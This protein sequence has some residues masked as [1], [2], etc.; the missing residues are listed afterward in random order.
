MGKRGRR[1]FTTEQFI[2]QAKKVHDDKYDY[3]KVEYMNTN[4]KVCIICPE[5]GEF[6][7]RPADHLLGHGCPSCKKKNSLK[8]TEQFIEQARKI[9]GDKYDYSKVDYKGSFTKVCIICPEHGEFWQTPRN[10]LNGHGCP[11][12]SY[13]KERFTTEQFIE[14][15]K[16]VHGDDK[17]DYS[18]VHYVDSRTK[19][20]LICKKC[21]REF[22][23]Y[24]NT[25]LQGHGCRRCASIFINKYLIKKENR[26]KIYLKTRCTAEQFIEKAK[27]IHGDKY[28]YSKIEY[29]NAHSKIYII[30]PIHGG[31]WQEANTH[32][33]GCGCPS[34]NYSSGERMI[35]NFLSNRTK[36]QFVYQ[37][38]T[39]W[40]ENQ[41]LDFFLP[42][43][44]L[45][46]EFDGIQHYEPSDFSGHLTE[47]ETLEEFKIIQERDKRKDEKCVANGI[48]LFRIKYDEDVEE[49]LTKILKLYNIEIKEECDV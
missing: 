42:D 25:H 18:K 43:Y 2:E 16:A 41:S 19:I 15:S 11:K 33:R 47:E 1:P 38:R 35:N 13:A 14:K 7:Q 29:K 49:A 46:I 44:N 20:L 24:P 8:L 21:G 22:W 28:D 9:H 37:Y 6:W 10:H 30:C 40:L 34:C 12:C 39:N 23:Q 32:L 17:F 36:E 5:H 4:I 3:S 27:K 48:K 31:F 45:G 26:E